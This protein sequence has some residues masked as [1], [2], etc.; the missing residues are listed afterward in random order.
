[1]VIDD[2]YFTLSI[3]LSPLSVTLLPSFIL[4]CFSWVAPEAFM[5][6]EV[7]FLEQ[8]GSN[9]FHP[10]KLRVSC[11]GTHSFMAWNFSAEVVLQVAK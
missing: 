5:D 11:R 7:D 6:K 2:F 10:V 4:I 1:M 8:G 3:T 9:E